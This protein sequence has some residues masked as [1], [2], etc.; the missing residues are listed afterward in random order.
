M[1]PSRM[2]CV[3][4]GMVICLVLVVGGCDA[5]GGNLETERSGTLPAP[6][7][8]RASASALRAP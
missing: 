4:A 6:S 3:L 8:T 5:G 1:R 2:T 7:V